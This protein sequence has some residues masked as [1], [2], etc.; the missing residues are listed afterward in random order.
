MN[1]SV[2]VPRGFPPDATSS[3][4]SRGHAAAD[5]AARLDQAQISWRGP[6]NERSLLWR[7]VHIFTRSLPVERC[8]QVRHGPGRATFL[9]FCYNLK[10]KAAECSDA[11]LQ[12]RKL[13]LAGLSEGIL[14]PV[15]WQLSAVR[16]SH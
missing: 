4:C 10:P 2:P 15:F 14:H 8:S 1:C 5:S 12:D 6:G 3:T 13:G 16:Q 9:Y 7:S 11:W